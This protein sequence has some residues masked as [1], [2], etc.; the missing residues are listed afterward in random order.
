MPPSTPCLKNDWRGCPNYASQKKRD[1]PMQLAKVAALQ[2]NYLAQD[3][4]RTVAPE[5]HMY[6]TGVDWYFSVGQDGINV[7]L[8]GLALARLGEVRRILDLPCGH[9]RVARHLR[10]AFPHADIT[11]AD[12]ET[13]GVDFC[14]SQFR[15]T[16]VYSQA[17][18]SKVDLGHNFDVIWI[19]SLFTHV[20][21]ARAET[22][23]RHLCGLLSPQGILIATIHGNWS[24]EVQR[25]YGA[26]IGD[27]EWAQIMAGYELTG[28]GYARYPG[29]EDYGVS[30]CRASTVIAMA[31]RIEG[32][33]ILGYNERAWAGN[34]DVL[35]IEGIDRMLKW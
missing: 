24:R 7:I 25:S 20:D 10:A 15:G 30:L 35:M 11:F 3:I 26:M 17:D 23:L 33:R 22:W 18:L 27:A 6:N 16:G 28:W 8:R 19:G 13:A 1:N 32:T 12:I 34:H 5:D 14:A 21:Q 2:A 29:A 31:S 9:G 4:D